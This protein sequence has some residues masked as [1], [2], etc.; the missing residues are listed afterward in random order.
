MKLTLIRRVTIKAHAID[1]YNDKS[2]VIKKADK[3]FSVVAWDRIDCIKQAEKQFSDANVYREVE[4][5]DK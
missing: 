4:S 2:I 1:K 3:D 5:K